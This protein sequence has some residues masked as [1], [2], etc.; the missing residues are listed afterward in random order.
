MVGPQEV[1][2][3]HVEAERRRRARDG[4]ALLGRDANS[5]RSAAA[6]Q[7]R[8]KLPRLPLDEVS[9]KIHIPTEEERKT[10]PPGR[11]AVADWFTAKYGDACYVLL[12]EA[13]KRAEVDQSNGGG[14][15]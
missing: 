6:M 15:P 3:C 14:S 4:R 11:K 2:A 8:T 1:D 7:V 12:Q 10:F 5:L 13:V 9:G